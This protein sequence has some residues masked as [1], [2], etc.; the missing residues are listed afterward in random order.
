MTRRF[1]HLNTT[2]IKRKQLG[3]IR[4]LLLKAREK[5]QFKRKAMSIHL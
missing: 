2:I 5:R 1:C 4:R 3:K